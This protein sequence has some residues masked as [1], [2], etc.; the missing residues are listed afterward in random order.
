[1]AEAPDAFL[2]TLQAGHRGPH[3]ACLKDRHNLTVWDKRVLI[4]WKPP[5]QIPVTGN[6]QT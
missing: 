5:L 6:S 2:C 4:P 3:V 1:M